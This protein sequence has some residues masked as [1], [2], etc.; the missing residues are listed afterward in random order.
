MNYIV[1]IVECR[2]CCKRNV[3]DLSSRRLG[4]CEWI[5]L[6]EFQIARVTTFLKITEPPRLEGREGTGSHHTFDNSTIRE[7]LLLHSL[8]VRRY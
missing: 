5:S 1:L 2:T 6:F 8:Y 3:D 4:K 7:C